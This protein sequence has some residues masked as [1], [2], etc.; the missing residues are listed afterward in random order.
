MKTLLVTLNMPFVSAEQ[1]NQAE[2]MMD[3]FGWRRVLSQVCTWIITFDS[4]YD[5]ERIHSAVNEQL[6][7]VKGKCKLIKLDCVYLISEEKI[8]LYT[9]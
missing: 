4:D 8:K 3:S 2:Y 6:Q 5:N 7:L 9:V 1:K